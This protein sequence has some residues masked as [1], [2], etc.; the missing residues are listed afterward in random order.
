MAGDRLLRTIAPRFDEMDI[1]LSALSEPREKPSGTIRITASLLPALAKI[2][3]N[4]P[5]IRIEVVI[6]YGLSNIVA[7]QYDTG[8]RPGDLV[9][10]DM[11]AV[12]IVLTCASRSS[13]RP[14]TS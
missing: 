6:D 2:L 7:E 9:A 13:A 3:P 10:K 14:P 12:R 5:D 1:E 4:Y 8:I 11:I